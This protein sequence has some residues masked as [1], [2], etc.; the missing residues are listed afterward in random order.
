MKVEEKFDRSESKRGS[1]LSPLLGTLESLLSN[2]IHCWTT[3]LTLGSELLTS[4]KP[5]MFAPPFLRS[6]RSMSRKPW[7]RK[8]TGREVTY[9]FGLWPPKMNQCLLA[10]PHQK[11]CLRLD[12]SCKQFRRP[13]S[14]ISFID[15]FILKIFRSPRRSKYPVF[16]QK[17][18][19]K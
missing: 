9:L 14:D 3:R 17:I 6:V 4:W 7:D 16:N 12:F 11:L 19:R 8:W 13:Y 18:L 10:T 15:S 2:S 1:T 5:V